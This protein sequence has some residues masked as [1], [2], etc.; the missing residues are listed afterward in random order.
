MEGFRAMHV[1]NYLGC[2]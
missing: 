1:T 2:A